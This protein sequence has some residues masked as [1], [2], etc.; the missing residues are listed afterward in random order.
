M[1]CTFLIRPILELGFRLYIN[2]DL[3][4]ELD[5]DMLSTTPPEN[6]VECTYVRDYSKLDDFMH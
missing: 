4:D 2:M 5:L 6:V 1:R 3:P